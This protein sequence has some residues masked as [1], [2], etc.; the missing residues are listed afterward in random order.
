MAVAL[1]RRRS[2]GPAAAVVGE[3]T[4][5]RI[6]RRRRGRLN[7]RALLGGVLVAV[8]GLGLFAG[9]SGAHSDHRI[10]FVVA[11]HDLQPGQR[12]TASDL[13]TQPMQLPSGLAGAEAFR[14]LSA[15]EGAVVVAPLDAGELV[16]VS[17]IVAAADAPAAA[18]LSF[19]I[20]A[21]RAVAGTL[22]AGETVSV[23]A[24]YGT[25]PQA[26]TMVV[27]SLAH[28]VSVS[29]SVTTLGAQS[30]EEV[31]LGLGAPADVL[32]LT[33]AVDAGQVELVRTSSG[34]GMPGPYSAGTASTTAGPKP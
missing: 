26:V 6:V 1:G 25:G 3:P 11:A 34:I 10:L 32:A 4:E 7:G 24:T 31:T 19:S 33:N 2:F 16:Q 5:L 14:T 9:Y 8:A 21:G 29:R 17:D 30:Q 23:L 28:V 20:D 13:T 15:L 12:L 18:E 27:V 22:Q